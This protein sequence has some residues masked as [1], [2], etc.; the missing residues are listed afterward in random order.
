MLSELGGP[1][2][3]PQSVESAPECRAQRNKRAE[4]AHIGVD[5]QE[6]TARD[7]CGLN[8]DRPLGCRAIVAMMEAADV[9]RHD[10]PP[11]RYRRDRA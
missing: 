7:C 1:A 5:V 8:V 4:E 2:P 3:S 9:R 10:D 11:D 6:D